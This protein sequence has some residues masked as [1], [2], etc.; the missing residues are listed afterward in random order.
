MTTRRCI[1]AMRIGLLGLALAALM[2]TAALAQGGGECNAFINVKYPQ[3]PGGVPTFL[4]PPPTDIDMEVA[5]GTGSI[6]GGPSNILMLNTFTLDLACN[7]D[8]L[9]IPSPCTPDFPPQKVA[10]VAMVQPTCAGSIFTPTVAGN[11]VT[12]NADKEIDIPAG[13]STLPGFCSVRFTLRVL[14]GF[15][16]DVTSPNLLEEAVS[17]G[18]AAANATRCD[19]GVLVSGGSQTSA[20]PVTT[21]PPEDFTCYQTKKPVNF[22]PTNP[23]QVNPIGK[24]V[25]MFGTNRDVSLTLVKRVCAPAA[26]SSSPPPGANGEHLVGYNVGK[27]GSSTF[28]PVKDVQVKTQQFGDLTVDVVKIAGRVPLLV[29]GFK[30]KNP[31]PN[32]FPPPDLNPKNHFL[33]YDLAKLRGAIPSGVPLVTDQFGSQELDL[34]NSKSWRLCAPVDKNDEDP[35]AE[36]SSSGLFCYVAETAN[37]SK[38][39][40]KGVKV[41]WATQIEPKGNVQKLDN[42]DD[43]CVAATI[44]KP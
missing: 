43:F 19:N 20:I 42:I 9:L 26:K 3:F 17:Y 1:A 37:G 31:P 25:D 22:D 23:D 11:V 12:F 36:T 29:P 34:V 15:S 2:P 40:V 4:I 44:I 5:F 24:L 35:D 32:V 8:H 38:N 10:F 28:Q 7:A 18:L 30:I 21:A 13:F 14:E 27:I 16:N 41:S 33:C 6:T 39:P